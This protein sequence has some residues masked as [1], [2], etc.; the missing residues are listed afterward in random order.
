MDVAVLDARAR[1]RERVS[2][3]VYKWSCT[4]AEQATFYRNRIREMVVGR[5]REKSARRRSRLLYPR[6]HT[7][8]TATQTRLRL[9]L[10]A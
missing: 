4:A 10:L 6:R 1:I 5:E 2:G 8:P 7:T 3:W 9:L